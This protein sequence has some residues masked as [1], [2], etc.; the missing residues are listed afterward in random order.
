MAGSTSTS[1][2]LPSV[3]SNPIVSSLP[4]PY[5]SAVNETA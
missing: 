2:G 1:V 5:I 4:G 3:P